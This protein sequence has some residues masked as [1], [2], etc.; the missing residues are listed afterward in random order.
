MNPWRPDPNPLQARRV[1]KSLEE[2]A[3]LQKVLARISIQG[4]F[5]VDPS[6]GEMNLHAAQKEIADVRAQLQLL[7]SLWQ[8]DASEIRARMEQKI[9]QMD[10]WEEEFQR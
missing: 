6:T 2:L 7:E 10:E 4:L 1:G 9:R 5:G 3:E 8:L